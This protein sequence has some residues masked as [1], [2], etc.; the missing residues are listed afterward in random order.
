MNNAAD[1]SL[2]QPL[3]NNSKGSSFPVIVFKDVLPSAIFN[4]LQEDI[5]KVIESDYEPPFHP[6][7]LTFGTYWW[8]SKNGD[9]SAEPRNAIEEAIVHMYNQVLSEVLDVSRMAGAEWW[10]QET[11][12]HDEPK[13]LHTDCDVQLL[14]D[15]SCL[16]QHPCISSVFYFDVIGGP[17]V[18]FDQT[19]TDH[20]GLV[21]AVPTRVA[22]MHPQP[23]HL[24]VFQ[25]DLFHGVLHP[26]HFPEGVSRYVLLVNWW[27]RRPGGPSSLPKEYCFPRDTH[28]PE[29]Q[30]EEPEDSSR[31]P[32]SANSAAV[33]HFEVC[34]RNTI[35]LSDA[36]EWAAQQIP[37]NCRRSCKVGSGSD[38]IQAPLLFTYADSTTTQFCG[39]WY[40]IQCEDK[41][42]EA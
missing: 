19:K 28:K 29:K 33:V 15:G 10:I 41:L 9:S 40:T 11:D 22:V 32:D 37:R 18:V 39:D 38:R 26:D 6:G 5:V 7:T 1:T 25:G 35:F 2:L 16:R 12:C 17:T 20:S 27:P 34:T 3:L 4:D 23:N 13:E 21:P 31:V 42:D 36:A 30:P 14:D 8:G 24:L